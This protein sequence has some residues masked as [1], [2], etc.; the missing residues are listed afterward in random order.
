MAIRNQQVQ[1]EDGKDNW[2]GAVEMAQCLKA[3]TALTEDQ[4]SVPFI[5][6]EA[7]SHL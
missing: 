1:V 6:M 2:V 5:H 4:N 7:H 3:L